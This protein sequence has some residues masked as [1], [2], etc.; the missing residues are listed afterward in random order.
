MSTIWSFVW[1]LYFWKKYFKLY[2]SVNIFGKYWRF[3]K[4]WSHRFFHFKI[5]HEQNKSLRQI[6]LLCSWTISRF[7][8][9]LHTFEKVW[10][11]IFTK[12]EI[13]HRRRNDWSRKILFWTFNFFGSNLSCAR[14]GV[15][16]FVNVYDINF[17]QIIDF[18]DNFI[19]NFC[20]DFCYKF[21]NLFFT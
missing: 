18:S 2:S 7:V 21:C 13:P 14:A 12:C 15:N 11:K 16:F 4:H 3:D 17:I 20:N 10:S 6:F 9:S 1:K 5:R 8:H 19:I